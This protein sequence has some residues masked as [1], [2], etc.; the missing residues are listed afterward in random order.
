MNSLPNTTDNLLIKIAREYLNLP[1]DRADEAIQRS[2]R[3]MAIFVGADR[4]YIFRYDLDLLTTSNTHEWCAEGITA[5]IDNLQNV[6]IEHIPEWLDAHKNGNEMYIPDVYA[7]PLDSGV[8]GL[9]EPQGVKSIIT[10]PMR[11]NQELIGFVGFD[12]VRTHHRYTDNERNLLWLYAEMLVNIHARE[13]GIA[14]IHVERE[15]AE[16]A[17]QAK[18][19]FLANMSHEIRTP[20]NAVIGY[21]EL[22]EETKLSNQQRVF[23]ETIHY[24]S[25]IL[26]GIVNDLLDFS[27]I[28]AGKINLECSVFSIKKIADKLKSVFKEKAISRGIE[29]DFVVDLKGREWVSADELRFTQILMN[30]INNALKF[31][32]TGSV[33][34]TIICTAIHKRHADYLISVEDTG[35]G[36]DAEFLTRLFEPF[37]QADEPTSRRYGGTGLG[38]AISQRIANAFGGAIHVESELGRGSKFYTNLSFKNVSPPQPNNKNDTKMVSAGIPDLTGKSILIAEDVKFNRDLLQYLLTPAGCKLTFAANG[39]EVV[40]CALKDDYDLILMDLQMP[41]LDGFDA[42][43]RIA[44]SKPHTLIIALSAAATE[45]DLARTKDCGISLHLAKPIRRTQL[46]DAIYNAMSAKS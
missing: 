19:Q 44:A 4:A 27:K 13:Q 12:S 40:D 36:M 31:T 21:S 37:E 38:L 41:I 7:L 32:Y 5:E 25:N 1:I 42:S 35:I 33:G 29:L 8:R 24:A 30:L 2:L 43:K 3:E 15:R 28:E 45:L 14:K 6:D 23:V 46:Y 34:V 10:I 16:K 18:S 11:N 26:L 20:L 39:Q 9:L 17:N 22:L